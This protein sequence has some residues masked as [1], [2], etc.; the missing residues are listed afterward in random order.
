VVLK[1]QRT[2]F[3]QF[4][5]VIYFF[6]ITCRVISIKKNLI[7]KQGIILLFKIG[8][9]RLAWYQYQARVSQSGYQYL[10]LFKMQEPPGMHQGQLL[11]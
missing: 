1:N 7:F 11:Q 6:S 8:F 9:L 10:L 2:G 3:D 4:W 5:L